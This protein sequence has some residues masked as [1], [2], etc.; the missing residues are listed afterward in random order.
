LGRKVLEPW[1][2][3]AMD[4]TVRPGLK[5]M[6]N[7]TKIQ[8]G[9]KEKERNEKRK[10][11]RSQRQHYCSFQKLLQGSISNSIESREQVSTEDF[12]RSSCCAHQP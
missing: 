11:G 12:E 8:K 5:K 9:Q 6:K 4:N 3:R 1:S 10:E 7:K 2:S